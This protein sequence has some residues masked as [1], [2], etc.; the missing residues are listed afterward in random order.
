MVRFGSAAVSS[1]R[2]WRSLLFS[3]SRCLSLDFRALS[4]SNMEQATSSR[5]VESGRVSCSSVNVPSWPRSACGGGPQQHERDPLGDEVVGVVAE[6][7]GAG[8]GHRGVAQDQIGLHALE[9]GQGLVAVLRH[10]DL[11]RERAQ[12]LHRFLPAPRVGID[13]QDALLGH[14]QPLRWVWWK[15]T[16]PVST[17]PRAIRPWNIRRLAA[18]EPAG[19]GSFR[20]CSCQL[21]APVLISPEDR[22]GGTP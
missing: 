8:P 9:Q 18:V 21:R 13:E 1:W 7:P 4:R 6:L 11:G 17:K 16:T 10:Q 2:D 12:H 15:G 3:S 19:P 5:P 22:D 20:V 14:L